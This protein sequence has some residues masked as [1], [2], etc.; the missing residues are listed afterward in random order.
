MIVLCSCGIPSK[1]LSLITVCVTPSILFTR[2]LGRSGFGDEVGCVEDYA[3][4]DT[5]EI[6]SLGGFMMYNYA[7]V[8]GGKVWLK[9][10]VSVWYDIWKY[11]ERDSMMTFPVTLMCC[12]YRYVSLLTI[13]QLIQRAMEL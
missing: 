7:A 13:F 3:S 8:C 6:T 12:E 5:K 11:C 1:N 9:I 4:D 10:V 2:M